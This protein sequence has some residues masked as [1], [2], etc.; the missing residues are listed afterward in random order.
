MKTAMLMKLL[1]LSLCIIG[2]VTMMSSCEDEDEP[3][4]QYPA[5]GFYGDNILMKG[6]TEYTARDNSLQARLPEGKSVKIV[7]TGKTVTFP[8]GVWF[9]ATGTSNNWAI[10]EF[11]MSDYTQIFQSIDGGL[12]CDLRMQFDEG[13]FQIDYYENGAASPTAT[14]TIVVDY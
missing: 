13:T 10:S 5:T 11:D 2:I 6:K 7:I 9:Y 4:I 14:K 3:E 12:T 1:Y 8:A